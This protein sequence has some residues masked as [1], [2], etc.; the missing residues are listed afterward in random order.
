M[1]TTADYLN[2]LVGQKNALADN[3]VTK[4][5][6]ATHDETLETLVPKVLN[7]SSG[8]GGGVLSSSELYTGTEYNEVTKSI[9][10][11]KTE[12][13][14][15]LGFGNDGDFI[16]CNNDGTLGFGIGSSISQHYGETRTSVGAT[17]LREQYTTIIKTENVFAFKHSNIEIH[18]IAKN[19]NGEYILL[20]LYG[21]QYKITTSS[22]TTGWIAYTSPILT[23]ARYTIT[24]MG[25][26]VDNSTFIN[27]YYVLSSRTNEYSDH[28]VN[29]NGKIFRLFGQ[30]GQQFAVKM[31]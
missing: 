9:S 24:S 26:L 6:T 22:M 12:I 31:N 27:L 4:G 11:L 25:G 30:S 19:Q 29:F 20:W 13:I 3:L 16:P 10:E 18:I 7:I 17:S 21:G 8:S 23:N 15:Y 1:A 5:V 28:F 2:K 14:D